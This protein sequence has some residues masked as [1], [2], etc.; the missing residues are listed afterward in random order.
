MVRQSDRAQGLMMMRTET[1][2]R[3]RMDAQDTA[4]TDVSGGWQGIGRP[5]K[6]VGATTGVRSPEGGVLP[7]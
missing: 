3:N 7:Q 6:N 5:L 4:K 2:R 1:M